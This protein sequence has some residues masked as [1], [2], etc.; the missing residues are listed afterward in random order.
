MYRRLSASAAL[1]GLLRVRLSPELRVARAYG[2]LAADER[3]S[4]P[5]QLATS[6]L[7]NAGSV[8]GSSSLHQCSALEAKARRARGMYA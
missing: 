3:C 7:R 5:I 8:L 1:S 6:E 4:V 2:P